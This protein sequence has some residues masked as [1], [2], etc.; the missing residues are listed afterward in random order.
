LNL[1]LEGNLCVVTGATRGIGAAT[2]SMLAQEGAD[3]LT[4]AR[5]D[6]HI[7]RAWQNRRVIMEDLLSVHPRASGEGV[8]FART[9]V[10]EVLRRDAGD[11]ECR[12]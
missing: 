2:A 10:S 4:V 6:A 5:S 8:L 1:G 11:I 7:E 9:R 12:D 3:V